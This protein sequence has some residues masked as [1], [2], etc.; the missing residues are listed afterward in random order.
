[1][2][3]EGAGERVLGGTGGGTSRRLEAGESSG[4]LRSR[5]RELT[6]RACSVVAQP[7]CSKQHPQLVSVVLCCVVLCCVVLCCVVLCCG[8]C[9]RVCVCV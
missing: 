5:T 8:V 3:G 4:E 7:S 1:M 2:L 9:V 6:A